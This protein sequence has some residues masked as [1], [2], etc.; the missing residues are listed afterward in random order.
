MKVCLYFEAEKLIQTSGIGRAFQHQKQALSEVGVEVCTDPDDVYDVLHINTYGI[1]S[2]SVIQ[3]ARDY[4]RPVI[5]HAHSTEEDFRNSFI[6]SNQIAPLLRKHL[7][8]LYSLADHII[9]PTPYAKKLLEN[10]GI[11]VPITPISNGIKLQRF[12]PNEEK[13]R[14]F[15]KYFGLSEQQKVIVSVGLYFERKGIFDF[16]ELA[17]AFPDITF[18]WF[19]HTPMISIPQAVRKAV[20]HP[21]DNVILPG[22]V[23]GPIIE[24]AYLSADL[25]LFASY[26]ETEGIVVLEALA[27]QCPLL[28]RDIPVYQDWLEDGVTCYKAKDVEG[29][30]TVIRAFY[31][32]Q[33]PDTRSAGHQLAQARSLE[34]VGEQLLELYQKVRS[35]V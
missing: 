28:I 32:H 19:G 7:I 5:Y 35:Q 23:R 10:Y 11:Q 27:A 17:R 26:E 3:K 8:H 15:R 22:Y 34:A 29:F 30:K 13:K 4:H 33:L 20:G 24:G 14:A 6:L 21:P 9:T 16:I 31:A 2:T 25:F 12:L 1:T 18:I